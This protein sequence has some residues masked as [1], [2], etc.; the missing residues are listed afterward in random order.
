MCGNSN[1][2]PSPNPLKRRAEGNYVIMLSP[3]ITVLMQNKVF[4]T[5]NRATKLLI[6]TRAKK[7]IMT[8]MASCLKLMIKDHRAQGETL[9]R[10]QAPR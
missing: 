9:D 4:F 8:S 7:G 10:D 1:F 2:Y 3:E 6:N 5:Q